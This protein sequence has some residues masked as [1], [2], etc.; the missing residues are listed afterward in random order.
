MGLENL[1]NLSEDIQTDCTII[2]NILI[3]M[4]EGKIPFLKN[5]YS[6][7]LEYLNRELIIKEDGEV[8]NTLP[9]EIIYFD[10]RKNHLDTS[11]YEEAIR[12]LLNE[13]IDKISLQ[14][15]A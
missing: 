15:Y 7:T 8:I 13:E 6:I 5:E 9:F 10:L 3:D 4:C 14:K 12:N 1:S 2:K 11:K